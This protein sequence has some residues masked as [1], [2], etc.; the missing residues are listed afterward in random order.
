[1]ELPLPPPTRYDQAARYLLL[2]AGALLF[3]WLLRLTAGQKYYLAVDNG[4]SNTVG[5]YRLT[6]TLSPDDFG[7]DLPSASPLT[8]APAILVQLPPELV[9]SST[10]S[11]SLL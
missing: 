10:A 1:M 8:L 9:D 5:G 6:F 11:V 4:Y 7:N 2:R 3:F